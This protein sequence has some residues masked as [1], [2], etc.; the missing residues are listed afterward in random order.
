MTDNDN[1]VLCKIIEL[2]IKYHEG[3]FRDNS[4]RSYINHPI[5]V[6]ELLINNG[7]NDVCVISAAYL[8]DVLEECDVTKLQLYNDINILVGNILSEQQINKIVDT[9]EKLTLITDKTGYLR[10]YR[11]SFYLADIAANCN[12]DFDTFVIKIVDRLCNIFEFHFYGNTKYAKKYML[13]ASALFG[14]LFHMYELD[15]NNTIL[16]N[17]ISVHNVVVDLINLK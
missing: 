6:G 15:I 9:V 16:K 11:K 2:A 10:K 3:Q 1:K 5:T 13:E 4:D 17:L 12:I 8:H 7:V 14:A